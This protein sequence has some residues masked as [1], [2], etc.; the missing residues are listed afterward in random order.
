MNANVRAMERQRLAEEQPQPD[1]TDDEMLEH[2]HTLMRINPRYKKAM[3]E[4]IADFLIQKGEG[5]AINLGLTFP[6]EE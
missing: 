5:V 3:E 2:V 6:P 1:L 4:L